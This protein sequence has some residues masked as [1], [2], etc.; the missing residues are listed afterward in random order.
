[1][2]ILLVEDETSVAFT[3]C[4]MLA[5]FGEVTWASTAADARAVLAKG[6]SWRAFLLD[7][8]LP[9][10]NGL[11]ILMEARGSYPLTPA[12]LY[13]GG[14]LDH[15]VVNAAFDWRADLITKPI[16]KA[17]LTQFLSHAPSQ[18]H[19]PA[20]IEDAFVAA[21]QIGA[22]L[23]RVRELK[24]EIARAHHRIGQIAVA[25]TRMRRDHRGSPVQQCADALRRSR[26]WLTRYATACNA[27]L[28]GERDLFEEFVSRPMLGG[29]VLSPAQYLE[30]GAQRNGHEWRVR[31][32][33]E[34]FLVKSLWG[35]NTRKCEVRTIEEPD[36][37]DS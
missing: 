24:Q 11:D 33:G 13:T 35:P 17:R 1:M 36:E 23:A 29:D 18:R 26:Q 34:D 15:E 9:D 10:G 14:Y 3:M 25:V 31:N 12:M 6:I 16:E 4:K 22:E 7:L 20:A 32:Y 30:H 5:R 19:L 27:V 37:D 28:V 2:Q 8:R 21:E